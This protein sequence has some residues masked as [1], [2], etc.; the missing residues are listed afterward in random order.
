M[1]YFYWASRLPMRNWNSNWLT[2]ILDASCFQTTYEELK[3]QFS[4]SQVL[5]AVSASRLPM[6]NWNNR[7]N[8]LISF[9]TASSLPIRNWNELASQESPRGRC[10]FRLPMRNWNRHYNDDYSVVGMLPDYLW[11]IETIINDDTVLNFY[12]FQ[13]TYE[14]LKHSTF[15]NGTAITMASRLPMRNWNKTP[16]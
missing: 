5:D 7:L 9:G 3:L 12:S 2:L 10:A 1:I 13:T 11:G 15:K 14:E 8:A 4:F 16:L 6:R